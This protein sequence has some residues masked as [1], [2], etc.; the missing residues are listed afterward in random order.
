MNPTLPENYLKRM[1][2]DDPEAYRSEVLGEFRTGASALFDPEA[3]EACVER[4]VRERL[5]G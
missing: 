4:G 1:E 5:L 2:E 3:I